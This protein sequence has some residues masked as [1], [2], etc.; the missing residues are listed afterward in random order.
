MIAVEDID[1]KSILISWLPSVIRRFVC[2]AG[3]VE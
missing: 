1:Q 2:P 3:M